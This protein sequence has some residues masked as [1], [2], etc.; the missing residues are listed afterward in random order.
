MSATPILSEEGGFGG[1]LGMLTDITLLKDQQRRLEQMAHYDALTGLPN[2]ILLADRLR[3]AMAHT[4]R[5]QCLLAV[6][7]L[8]LDGFKPVNDTHGHAAGDRL[9]IEIARRLTQSL[10][11]EDTAARLGGDEFVLLLGNL[12][13]DDQCRQM[14]DRLLELIAAPYP[15]DHIHSVSVSASIGVTLYPLDPVDADTLLRHADQ[16]MYR[17]K[18]A[19]RGHV[20]IHR[21]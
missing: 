9:L 20:M 6:C 21:A 4:Q 10:R 17:V 7:Y 18:Q 11:A 13:N 14:L 5:N 19:G 8:D 15:L 3:L 16:A 2:R 12:A 1:S